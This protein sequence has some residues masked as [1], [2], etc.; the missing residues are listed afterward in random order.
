M[1]LEEHERNLQLAPL[2]PA[3]D[4]LVGCTIGFSVS[5]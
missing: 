1:P 5:L 2:D 3:P 4:F